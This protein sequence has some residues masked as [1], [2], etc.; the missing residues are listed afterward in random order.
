MLSAQAIARFEEVACRQPI[1]ARSGCHSG[2][3]SRAQSDTLLKVA[4]KYA[5]EVTPKRLGAV[6]PDLFP[7]RAYAASSGEV[8]FGISPNAAI[9]FVVEVWAA[10]SADMRLIACVNRTPV[11]DDIDAVH[12]RQKI[13][14]FGC[15]LRHTPRPIA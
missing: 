9:P 15:G 6:G 5:R 11:T 10:E 3:L 4:R 14:L 13:N 2:S 8:S 12:N 1:L 7:D